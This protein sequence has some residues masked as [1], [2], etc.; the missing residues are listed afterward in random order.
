M[1]MHIGTCHKV[2]S[3][4]KHHASMIQ[5]SPGRV[6]GALQ[7]GQS[8]NF[9][10]FLLLNLSLSQWF[11]GVQETKSCTSTFRAPG[12]S[13]TPGYILSS[14]LGMVLSEFRKQQ[15]ACSIFGYL[16]ISSP[17]PSLLL[18]ACV[19]LCAAV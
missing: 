16:L 6:L 1:Q 2:S 8:G 9:L 14:S 12:L 17:S 19:T 13:V 15:A 10:F 18:A 11:L 4:E 5:P 7:N 3:S